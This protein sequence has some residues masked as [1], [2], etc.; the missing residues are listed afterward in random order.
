[1]VVALGLVLV[2][3]GDDEPNRPSLAAWAPAW[4]EVRALEPSVEQAEAGGTDVCGEFLG[5]V[6]DRR[7]DVLPTPDPS[8][9]GPTEAWIE[10]AE[11]VGLD[12]D[13]EGDLVANLEDLQR[14]A[15]A[16]DEMVDALRS[17]GG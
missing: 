4:A 8:L 13:R 2:A 15:D 10:E 6:R 7:Q 12:C 14:R 11:T 1:M 5:Q 17:G 3:C 9:D 16:I